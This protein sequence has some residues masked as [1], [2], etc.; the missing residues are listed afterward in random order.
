MFIFSIAA[1]GL[2]KRR[3][4]RS[5]SCVLFRIVPPPFN[6]AVRRIKLTIQ[7]FDYARKLESSA[8]TNR[9]TGQR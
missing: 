9:A 4:V 3:R 6:S 2:I 5:L 1:I 7:A 8:A